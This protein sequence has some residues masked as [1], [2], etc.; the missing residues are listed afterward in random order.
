MLHEREVEAWIS[1]LLDERSHG[2]DEPLVHLECLHVLGLVLG[3]TC[4]D[5]DLECLLFIWLK[6]GDESLDI[7]VNLGLGIAGLAL[8]HFCYLY[9]DLV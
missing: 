7:L 9:G 8:L 3:L 6:T 1:Y 5:E 2:F 4:I